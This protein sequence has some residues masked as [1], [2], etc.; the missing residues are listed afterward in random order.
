M[1]RQF[2]KLECVGECYLWPL[3]LRQKWLQRNV[4]TSEAKVAPARCVVF[5]IEMFHMK[6]RWGM[7]LQA[8]KSV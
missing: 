2:A 6:L 4:S 7:L 3:C 8:A 5:L 1:T